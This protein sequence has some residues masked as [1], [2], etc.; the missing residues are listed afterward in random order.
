MKP[1]RSPRRFTRDGRKELTG[2]TLDTERCKG[3]R[4]TRERAADEPGK[5]DARVRCR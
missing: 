5:P 4:F 3:V 2:F 1:F